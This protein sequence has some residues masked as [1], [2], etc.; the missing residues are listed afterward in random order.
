MKVGTDGCLL[1]AWADA[2]NPQHI[3]DIGAGTGLIALMLAQRF[4]N[5]QITAVEI[6]QNCAKQCAENVAK[7]PFANRILT[8]NLPLQEFKTNVAFD[9]IASNPPFFTQDF[10][11]ENEHRQTARHDAHLSASDLFFYAEK[12]L[13]KNGTFC[14]V[15]PANREADFTSA[16]AKSTLFLH[17]KV[18]V[19]PTPTKA[20]KRVLLAFKRGQSEVKTAE[21]LVEIS[22]GNYS[23][24]FRKLL[25][26]FYLYL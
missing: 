24:E 12:L 25:T 9:L 16:A 6:E 1:G 26:D 10:L 14:L 17:Q 15:I 21:L 13:S 2:D 7:S 8:A 11:P 23:E 19:K 20:A 3:L 4:K 22:R 5:A 18:L